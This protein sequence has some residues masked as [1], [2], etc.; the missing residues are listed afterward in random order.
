VIKNKK[1]KIKILLIQLRQLGDILLTTPLIPALKELEKKTLR[2]SGTQLEI[3]F[4]S[5]QMGRLILDDFDDLFRLWTY[6]EK[7][8][9][10]EQA[11]LVAD[12]RRESFDIVVDFMNNPRS[13]L[14]TFLTGAAHRLGFRSARRWAYHQTL[15][16][17]GSHVYIVQEKLRFVSEINRILEAHRIL[18]IETTQALETPKFPL[19]RIPYF[20]KDAQKA[21]DFFTKQH[22]TPS[23]R[24]VMSPTHRHLVRQWPLE[25]FA[26]TADWLFLTG[27]LMAQEAGIP[28]LEIFWVWGPGEESVV[29]RCMELC[30]QPT[31]KLPA[32]T[33][34]EM[35]A[36]IANCDMFIGNSNGPSHVAVSVQTPSLQLHGPTDGRSWCPPM[37][38]H[39]Y[40]QGPSIESIQVDDITRKIKDLLS[41]SI[42]KYK[43]RQTQPFINRSVQNYS[44][45]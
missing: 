26:A 31:V 25:H 37:D 33:F 1:N 27:Q 17:G 36:F 42:A 4:L 44:T 32:T 34:R 45:N 15:P 35:A 8:S 11:Q 40:L 10:L 18:P 29:D 13:A 43:W 24:I 6:H 20:P 12:L 2:E 7:A 41:L 19:P 9:L 28:G 38:I 30:T 16:K 22:P 39:Q 3:S 5:H 21:L 14:L 23:L